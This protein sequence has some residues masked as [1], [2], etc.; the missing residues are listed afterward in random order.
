MDPFSR[1]LNALARVNGLSETVRW[2]FFPGMLAESPSKWWQDFSHRA[3]HHEGID[4]CYYLNR[5]NVIAT[6]ANGA[7]IPAW[8]S[9]MVRN[10]CKDFT[11]KTIIVEPDGYARSLTRVLICYAH[12]DPDQNIAPGLQ[13]KKNQIVGWTAD[14]GKNSRLPAHLHLSCVELPWDIPDRDLDWRLF[15]CR[16]KV[17]L[18]NPVFI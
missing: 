5:S 2:L 11:G 9:G 8:T 3:A 1:Y 7:A 6:L 17:N 14:T 12:L 16:Q 15:T 10:I 13:V 4:I 18:I